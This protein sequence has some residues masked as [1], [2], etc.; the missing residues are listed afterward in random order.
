MTSILEMFR[1]KSKSKGPARVAETQAA[2]ERLRQERRTA[3]A[4][5]CELRERRE[6]ELLTAEDETILGIDRE[7]NSLSLTL[8]RLDAAE[9]ALRQRLEEA[10]AVEERD[11][12]LRAAD[13]YARALKELAE[14]QRRFAEAHAEAN[15]VRQRYD[16]DLPARMPGEPPT[17]ADQVSREM[18]GQLIARLRSAASA[19]PANGEA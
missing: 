8:E 17:M 7:L 16:A 19:A 4:Q 10:K 13:A 1:H 9:P 15:A 3:E 11:Q 18:L 14:A 6:T 5:V 12:R 2:L